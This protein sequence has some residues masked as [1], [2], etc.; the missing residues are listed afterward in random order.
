MNGM[1][2]DL[3]VVPTNFIGQMHHS[4]ASLVNALTWQGDND[5]KQNVA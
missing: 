3:T 5:S 2:S 4:G 1:N